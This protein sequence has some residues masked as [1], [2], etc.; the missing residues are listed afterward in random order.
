MLDTTKA[1]FTYKN[2]VD[3]WKYGEIAFTMW[4]RNWNCLGK[5]EEENRA[6][7]PLCELVADDFLLTSAGKS[8]AEAIDALLSLLSIYVERDELLRPREENTDN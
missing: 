7:G 8:P 3:H 6:R 5:T 1:E 4:L 2:V